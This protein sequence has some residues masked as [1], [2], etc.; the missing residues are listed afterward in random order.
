MCDDLE[1]DEELDGRGPVD[2]EEGRVPV[3][4]V[5]QAGL[6]TGGDLVGGRSLGERSGGWDK[7]FVRHCRY[8][9]AVGGRRGTATGEESRCE[10]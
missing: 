1:E 3:L 9:G 10:P 5:V 8:V 6:G 4:C 2:R 7:A